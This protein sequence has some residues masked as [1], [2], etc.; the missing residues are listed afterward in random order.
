M[1]HS[2]CDD[3]PDV[4][5]AEPVALF[6]L[7]YSRFARCARRGITPLKQWDAFAG[8]AL[9]PMAQIGT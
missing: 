5:V 4:L 1:S 2:P 9:A 7:R 6:R 3:D 8:G